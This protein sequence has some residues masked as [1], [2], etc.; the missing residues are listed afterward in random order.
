MQTL[1]PPSASSPRTPSSRSPTG[2]LAEVRNQFARNVCCS[3][4]R[5][6]TG[7]TLTFKVL[8]SWAVSCF[9]SLH[10]I[11]FIS[12]YHSTFKVLVSRAVW[13]LAS[14]S[15]LSKNNML[16]RI[17]EPRTDDENDGRNANYEDDGNSCDNGQKIII[18]AWF[19]RFELNLFL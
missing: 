18:F 5:T 4:V 3:E 7:G 16:A 15:F 8:F 17:T 9:P 12:S 1:T 19:I 14:M 11:H 6:R 10:F 2:F 13:F